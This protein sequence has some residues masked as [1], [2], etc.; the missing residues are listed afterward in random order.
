MPI[1]QT[2]TVLFRVWLSDHGPGCHV[3]G[4]L[5]RSQ[6]WNGLAPFSSRYGLAPLRCFETFSSRR[7]E[8]EKHV[9]NHGEL[10]TVYEEMILSCPIQPGLG[11]LQRRMWSWQAAR[12]WTS[13]RI[14]EVRLY[15]SH[16]ATAAATSSIRTWVA[17]APSTACGGIVGSW[18]AF[19]RKL[20]GRLLVVHGCP[21]LNNCS[22]RR[23]SLPCRRLGAGPSSACSSRSRPQPRSSI[24]PRWWPSCSRCAEAALGINGF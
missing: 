12:V 20:L 7:Y 8:R 17:F 9:G 21:H 10:V 3:R 4:Q 13:W 16:V 1:P 5:S 23:P 18:G 15:R 2:H 24:A 6:K 22:V 14:L 11:V 19:G